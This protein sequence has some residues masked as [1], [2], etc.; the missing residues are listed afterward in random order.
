[1]AVACQNFPVANWLFENGQ[2]RSDVI[3]SSTD[4]RDDCTLLGWLIRKNWNENR[5]SI[6][7]LL[8]EYVDAP[9]PDF[10]VTPTVGRSALQEAARSAPISRL[11]EQ[12]AHDQMQYLVLRYPGSRHLEYQ[13]ID[14]VN[15]V[16]GDTQHAA[17]IHTIVD[18]RPT[19]VKNA[20]Q[21]ANRI[22][23]YA[24]TKE[25]EDNGT[26]LHFAVRSINFPAVEVLLEAGAN[27]SAMI[28]MP[29]PDSPFSITRRPGSTYAVKENCWASTVL[30]FAMLVSDRLQSDSVAE[31]SD[32]VA[33]V[34]NS[35]KHRYQ[36]QRIQDIITMLQNKGAANSVTFL[37]KRGIIALACPA[38]C[39][40]QLRAP[41]F[42]ARALNAFP[43]S[44][45]DKA[46]LQRGG[47]RSGPRDLIKA[48]TLPGVLG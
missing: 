34:F 21:F 46:C 17:L 27:G 15:D 40:K 41:A 28:G 36:E 12:D 8:E 31:S 7:Y 9:L 11:G 43:I 4:Q 13:R 19:V 39:V 23:D 30:D 3:M 10:I 16:T 32:S 48:A 1:M 14:K 5:N 47:Y 26:A 45:N 38:C 33:G 29:L 25:K 24:E 44:Q 6:V 22:M 37:G 42:P 20:Y 35:A 2:S 18:G